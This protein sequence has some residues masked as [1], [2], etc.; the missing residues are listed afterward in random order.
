MAESGSPYTAPVNYDLVFIT[1]FLIAA[2]VPSMVYLLRWPGPIA[3][4]LALTVARTGVM[5]AGAVLVVVTVPLLSNQ[6]PGA[7]SNAAAAFMSALLVSAICLGCERSVVVRQ[8]AP[9]AS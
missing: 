1:L 9:N 7:D 5:A 4:F 3:P 6:G 2:A 8:I